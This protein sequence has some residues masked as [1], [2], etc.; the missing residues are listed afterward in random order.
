MA[1]ITRAD[2]SIFYSESILKQ[3]L[4][5]TCP[6]QQQYCYAITESLSNKDMSHSYQAGFSH[7][8]QGTEKLCSC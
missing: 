2:T 4:S 8:H 6:K 1:T 5:D 7:V 3:H